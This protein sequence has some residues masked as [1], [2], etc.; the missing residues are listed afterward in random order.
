MILLALTFTLLIG[1]TL[2]LSFTGNITHNTR[3]T[4]N[5]TSLSEDP[6]DSSKSEPS[7]L[8]SVTCGRISRNFIPN[9]CRAIL[10]VL[11]LDDFADHQETWHHF[12][13]PEK[14][15]QDYCVI[16]LD[17]VGET[18]EEKSK[19]P[20]NAEDDFSLLEIIEV[21]NLLLK[22]V[23]DL[24]ETVGCTSGLDR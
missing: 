13:M 9:H 16:T 14:Y 5:T 18:G 2:S 17:V 10:Q 15:G 3:T 11:R 20:E 12:D 8:K 7:V 22:G 23:F 6:S 19:I 1:H 24:V 21:S 4:I